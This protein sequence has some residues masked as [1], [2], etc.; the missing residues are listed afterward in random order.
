MMGYSNDLLSADPSI[1]TTELSGIES[2]LRISHPGIFP[3]KQ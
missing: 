3:E 1:L 2:R